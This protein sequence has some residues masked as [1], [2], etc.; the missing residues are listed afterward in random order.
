MAPIRTDCRR[1]AVPDFRM[2]FGMATPY[3]RTRGRSAGGRRRALRR[4]QYGFH[5]AARGQAGSFGPAALLAR[6]GI[7]RL[8]R[9]AFGTGILGARHTRPLPRSVAGVVR[10]DASRSGTRPRLDRVREN[11]AN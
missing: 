7:V 10:A 3:R 1:H 9:A 6:P 8:Q 11:A 5:G 2:A 4:W